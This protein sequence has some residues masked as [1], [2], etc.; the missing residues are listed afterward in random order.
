MIITFA[1]VIME[2]PGIRYNRLKGLKAVYRYVYIVGEPAY[3]EKEYQ[4]L[5]SP[6]RTLRKDCI[7][8]RYC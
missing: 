6:L 2:M 4:R 7:K 1:I 3:I 5:S 8:G